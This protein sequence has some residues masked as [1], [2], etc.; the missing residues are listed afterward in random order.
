M[1]TRLLT[2]FLMIVCVLPPLLY[3]GW[4]L[5]LLLAIV[6]ILAGDEVLNLSTHDRKVPAFFKPLCIGMVL[7]LL[8]LSDEKLIVSL[9]VVFFALLLLPVFFE[10]I[11]AQD[12]FVALFYIV[13][14]FMMANSFNWMY[15]LNSNI[16]WLI[17][18]V[19]YMCDS[20]A[21]FCGRFFGKHKLNVRISPKK[22]W[23]GAIGGWI[24]GFIVAL[25]MGMILF[26]DYGLGF[27]LISALVL[28]ISGQLGDL[29]FSAMK[30]NYKLKDFSNLLPGHG[31]ILDRLDSLLFNFVVCACILVVFVL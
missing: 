16:I 14:F 12:I 9:G 28:P 5:N 31:G 26:K 20:A 2:A 13:L 3:G 10:S 27:I 1:K 4:S 17:M 21:Y 19:T 11:M 8:W 22:T 29:I 6:V 25:V 18:T 7:F 15:S 23:E 30:R 24:V